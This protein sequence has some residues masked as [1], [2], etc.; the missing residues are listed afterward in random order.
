[1]KKIVVMVCLIVP[2]IASAQL[3]AK[4]IKA[5]NGQYIGFYQHTPAGWSTSTVKYPVIIF[6]HGVSERGNGT[7]ELARVKRVALPK[8]IDQ[9][10]KT[11]KYYVNGK[12]QTFVVVSPQ[13][14]SS[15]GSWQNFYIDEMINYAVKYLKGDPNRIILTGLSLGGGGVW[16]YASYSA[17]NA[18]KLAAI[19]PICG[20]NAMTNAKNI[21]VNKL[22]VWAF[23]SANDPRVSASYTKSAID[24]I[25]AAYPKYKALYFPY[26]VSTH[27]VWD[28]AFDDVY[29]YQNPHIFEWM[30]A[31]NKA[32]AINATPTVNAGADVT[33]SR[34]TAKAVVYGKG[35]DVDGTMWRY[36]WKKVSGPSYG[37]I[38]DPK[39]R[40]LTVTGLKVAGTYVYE[41]KG[42]DNDA[43]FRSDR[44]TI[45]VK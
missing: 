34:S 36:V 39:N 37:T 18:S 27:V 20:T 16:K 40:T 33:I 4:R 29:K 45:V 12:W 14:S 44:A 5:V 1:M 21:A 13:L 41:L 17:T 26:T 42:V 25:N 19:V 7:T 24:K 22:A 31:Q 30:L 35:S 8:Y 23:H 15:Y 11:M 28:M 3:V 43:A 9:R 38:L 6:L 10:T 2:F 32:A